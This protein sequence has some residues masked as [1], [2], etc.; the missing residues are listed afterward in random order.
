VSYSLACPGR[1]PPYA[2]EMLQQLTAWLEDD[3]EIAALVMK[4]PF[5]SRAQICRKN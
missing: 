1:L 3:P 5:V 4:E 2:S